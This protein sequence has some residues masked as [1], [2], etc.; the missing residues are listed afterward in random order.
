MLDMGPYYITDLVNLLGP[1]AKVA[2]MASRVRAERLVG[3]QPLAGTYV[4]V[5]V[6]THVAGT[7]EF[8]SGA[9][10]TVV[11]SFDVARHRHRPIELYGTEGA[12]SVPDPNWFGGE[13]ELA[14]AADDWHVVPTEHIYADGNYRIIGV[15][16]MA[17]A[18]RSGRPHRANGDIAFH[19]LEV[20]EAF[21]RSA[22][23]GTHVVIGSRP[24]R[25]AEMPTNRRFGDLD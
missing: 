23:S 3:S 6:A 2:G 1:V 10:V 19:V 9:I 21:Q 18:I 22:D 5:E 25:P 12:I 16:D 8:V 15:A 14:T 13:I 24:D 17:A 11:M 7:L 4:P 20:M